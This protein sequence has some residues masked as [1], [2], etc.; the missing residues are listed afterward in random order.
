MS[1]F[2]WFRIVCTH[3]SRSVTAS[4]LTTSSFDC[5]QINYIA[6][7]EVVLAFLVTE[8]DVL[9]RLLGTTH[10]TLGERL[11][12]WAPAIAL[13]LLWELG[14]LIA[15][16]MPHPGRSEQLQLLPTQRGMTGVGVSDD[17]HPR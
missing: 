5:K 3:E 12:S 1:A 13:L 7:G 10:I 8:W 17:Y 16:R 6:I 2:A 9:N 4:A 11:L 14:K 15:R